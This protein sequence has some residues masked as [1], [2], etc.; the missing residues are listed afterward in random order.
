MA[1]S[2]DTRTQ[3][4][5][6]SNSNS[7]LAQNLSFVSEQEPV[8]PEVSQQREKSMRIDREARIVVWNELVVLVLDLTQQLKVRP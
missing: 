6:S 1:S 7:A 2:D 8:D 5:N 3:D 4:N